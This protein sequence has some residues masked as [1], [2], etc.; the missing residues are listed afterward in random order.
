[1]NWETVT[2]SQKELHWVEVISQDVQG[3]LACARAASCSR[4]LL[5]MSNASEPATAKGAQRLWRTPAATAQPSSAAGV[6]AHPLR[7]LQ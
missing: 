2:L 3:N 1:M 5:G 6:R 7:R 4:L